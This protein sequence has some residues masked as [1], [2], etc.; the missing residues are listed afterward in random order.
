M[1]ALLS[2]LGAYSVDAF[3]PSLRA[4][5]REFGIE[6]RHGQLLLTAYLIPHA[7]MA[8]LHGALS[9]AWGRRRVLLIALAI[10]LCASLGCAFA[11]G[12]GTLLAMR[13][14]QGVVAGAGVIVGR[15]IVRDCYSGARAQRVMSAIS[16]TFGLGPA[17][18]PTVG[19][20]VEVTLGWRAVFSTMALAATLLALMVVRR[21]PE[22]LPRAQRVPAHPVR[23]ATNIARVCAHREFLPIALGSSLIWLAPQL[24]LGAAPWVIFDHWHGSETRFAML[25]FPIILGY[26]MGA[27]ISGR[28]AGLWPP[29]RQAR[30]GY[31]LLASAAGLM[32]LLQY[33]VPQL[34]VLAQ[35]ALLVMMTLGL[36][37]MYPIA[38]LRVLDLFPDMRG[39]AASALSGIAIM[40]SAI[41]MG[42][43]SPWLAV[44]LQRLSVGAFLCVAASLPLWWQVRARAVPAAAQRPVG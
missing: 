14:L 20:W 17:I 19:G 1:L 36:Q 32:V 2:M 8:M 29:E 28:L 44:S 3:F 18:G 33:A 37:M 25:M 21:L 7:C 6:P 13:A 42:F 41:G 27:F 12:F 24:W 5:T 11:P 30:T 26:M 4:I 22:T 34:P 40:C 31:L 9:D 38:M 35:Q 39:A 16:I 10:Y 23:L 15:A 43:V